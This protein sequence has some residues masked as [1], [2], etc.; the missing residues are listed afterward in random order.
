LLVVIGQ[1]FLAEPKSSVMTIGI[2]FTAGFIVMLFPRPLSARQTVRRNLA[3]VIEDTG[4]LYGKVLSG[5]EDESDAKV[6]DGDA[7]DSKTKADKYR[8]QFLKIMVST[9]KP[10][11]RR[12][13][14]GQGQIQVI[15]Q[16]VA[17]ASSVVPVSRSQLT[18]GS[19]HRAEPGI[20]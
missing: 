9:P 20:R 2:G 10:M 14:M 15:Q 13:T 8:G 12:L 3:R 16:Q 4:N 19:A 11:C 17:F 1:H 18:D 5:V 6:K 7:V